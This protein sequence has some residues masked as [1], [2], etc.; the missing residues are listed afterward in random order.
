MQNSLQCAQRIVY[1]FH[2]RTRSA[3]SSQGVQTLRL[4]KKKVLQPWQA[5]KKL[6]YENDEQSLKDGYDTYVTNFPNEKPLAN[7]KKKT[8]PDNYLTWLTKRMKKEHD[9]SNDEI[10]AAVEKYHQ[11]K[12]N[13]KATKEIEE[14]DERNK[15]YQE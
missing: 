14:E 2:Y 4:G 9:L 15:Q 3:S 8:T 10:K 7:S 1:W 12:R 11:Q 6:Y 5:F 13:I